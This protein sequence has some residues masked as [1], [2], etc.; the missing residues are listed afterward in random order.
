MELSE[1]KKEQVKLKCWAGYATEDKMRDDLKFSQPLPL[2]S[3]NESAI[4]TNDSP[5]FT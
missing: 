2:Q 5:I 4:D 3:K 1:E